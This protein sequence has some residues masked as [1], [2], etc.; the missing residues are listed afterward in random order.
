MAAP[1]PPSSARPRRRRPRAPRRP[2][3]CPMAPRRHRTMKRHARQIRNGWRRD[4]EP[5]SSR[6]ARGRQNVAT[7]SGPARAPPAPCRRRRADG[8]CRGTPCRVVRR[9]NFF[10]CLIFLLYR[11][12][13]SRASSQLLF[14]MAARTAAVVAAGGTC[15]AGGY[16]YY[17]ARRRAIA[18]AP[19]PVGSSLQPNKTLTCKLREREAISAD[20]AR[21]RF[22]LPS[23]QHVLGLPTASHVLAVDGAMVYRAYTPITLDA[24]D[25]GYFDLLVKRYPGG[26]FSE[27]FHRMVCTG[28]GAVGIGAVRWWCAVCVSVGCVCVCVCGGGG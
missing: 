19:P 12:N 13:G 18:N 26:E 15:A 10:P 23:D 4:S 20:T 25:K 8:R 9:G 2:C 27:A 22:E 28:I 11:L 6:D 3:C 1:S 24:C 16:W 5:R 14:S 7:A 17:S 21:F